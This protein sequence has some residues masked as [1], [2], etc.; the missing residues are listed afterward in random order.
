MSM[1]DR[2]AKL[3]RAVRPPDKRYPLVIVCRR[4]GEHDDRPP[5]VYYDGGPGS[6]SP[7]VVYEG[8]DP[9]KAVLA[10]FRHPRG[11]IAC[12]SSNAVQKWFRDRSS[13]AIHQTSRH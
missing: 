3:E 13:I 11:H 12:S 7:T 1:R 5:G 10:Q 9:P 6:V 4:T 8:A 2:I